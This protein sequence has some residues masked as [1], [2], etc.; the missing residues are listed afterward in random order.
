MEQGHAAPNEDDGAADLLVARHGPVMLITFNRPQ[1]RNALTFSMYRRLADAIGSI[2]ESGAIRA[3]VLTGA[4]GK[5][6][7]AGTDIGEFR[8][9]R[10]ATDAIAYEKS[11]SEILDAIEECPVP[12]IAAIAGACTGGG[13]GIAACCDLRLAASNA[14]F[15]LPMARTLGNCLSLASHARFVALLGAA[16][17][18][19]LVLTARLMD[20]QE[21]HA[22]GAL[23]EIV[24]EADQLLPRA[25]ALA[26]TIASHAPLTMRVTKESLRALQAPI[27]P[28]IEE[29]LFLKAYLSADFAEGVDAFLNKRAPNWTGR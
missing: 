27:D 25:M 22:A 19:D 9:F 8:A 21:L 16:R 11:I 4:G 15:G 14:R 26:E 18:R 3:V 28:A 1:S 29:A 17:V 13:I 6:F 2:D 5:A 23:T 7:A 20:A 10:Y 24:E 12:T